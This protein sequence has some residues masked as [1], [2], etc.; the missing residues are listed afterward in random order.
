MQ[1]RRVSSPR[2]TGRRWRRLLN[3]RRKRR[4]KHKLRQLLT[5]GSRTTWTDST[6][7]CIDKPW[8]RRKNRLRPGKRK[9]KSRKSRSPRSFLKNPRK[10]RLPQLKRS[11][12]RK[13]SEGEKRRAWQRDF[14]VCRGK[15]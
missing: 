11:R 2:P 14:Y 4:G 10:W 6:G 7:T 1:T 13:H 3:R 12:R 15:V 8:E 5:S 9:R